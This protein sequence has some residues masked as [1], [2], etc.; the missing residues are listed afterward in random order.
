M[1]PAL[2][3]GIPPEIVCRHVIRLAVAADRVWELVGSFDDVRLGC[4]LVVSRRAA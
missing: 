2:F 3:D 4:R 1:R